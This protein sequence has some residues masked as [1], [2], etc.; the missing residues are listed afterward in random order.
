MLLLKAPLVPPFGH[1]RRLFF[2]RFGRGAAAA[3]ILGC[4]EVRAS[5]VVNGASTR[6]KLAPV[7]WLALS[8]DGRGGPGKNECGKVR[9]C[10]M[11]T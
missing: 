1:Q 10:M 7:G 8:P 4:L 9:G 5:A 11:N 3:A 6:V 2:G